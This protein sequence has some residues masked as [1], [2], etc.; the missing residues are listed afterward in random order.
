MMKSVRYLNVEPSSPMSTS[1]PPDISH[2]MS[3]PRPSLFFAALP[4]PC[5]ILNANRRTKNRGGLGTRLYRFQ[6]QD[7]LQE[8]LCGQMTVAA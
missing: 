1:H 2:M 8:V 6:C 3:I 5:I 7:S 4:L